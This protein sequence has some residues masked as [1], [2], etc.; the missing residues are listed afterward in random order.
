M[1]V[2]SAVRLSRRTVVCA[3]VVLCAAMSPARATL[4]VVPQAEAP[5]APASAP[6]GRPAGERPPPDRPAPDRPA[7]GHAEPRP[8]RAAPH[9]PRDKPERAGRVPAGQAGGASPCTDTLTELSLGGPEPS[10]AV[11]GAGK[12]C[13]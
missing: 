7:A 4:Q 8:P 11:A 9:L 3:L 1:A 13:R 5:A 10:R 2:I 6:S 12:P